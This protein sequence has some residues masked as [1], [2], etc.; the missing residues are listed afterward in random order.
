M[1]TVKCDLCGSDESIVVAKGMRFGIS[2][3]NVAC[4]VCGMVYQNPRLTDAQLADFYKSKYRRLYSGSNEAPPVELIEEQK[5]RGNEILTFC[6]PWLDNDALIL[7]VG[8]GPGG[9][10]LPFRDSGFRACGIEPGPYALW[11]AQNLGLTIL[12]GTLETVQLDGMAPG[13][14]ILSFMLEHVPS[15]RSVLS[16]VYRVLPKKGFLFVEVPNLRRINGPIEDFFHVAHLTF[17]TPKTIALMLSVTGYSIAALDSSDVYSIRTVSVPKPVLPTDESANWARE[18]D[19]A[20]E[21]HAFLRKHERLIGIQLRVMRILR[22]VRRLGSRLLT[23]T[24]GEN[25]TKRIYR[26]CREVWMKVRYM[27]VMRE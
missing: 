7:D 27:T 16:Q 11:G 8:C 13:L 18:G 14:I 25:A 23:E 26:V 3:T 17:F 4:K 12:Q 21:I 22:P 10:L 2:T 24:I 5:A 19:K 9:T 6:R 1:K 15:P 20:E